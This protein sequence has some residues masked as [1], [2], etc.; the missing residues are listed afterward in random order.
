MCN[1]SEW[2]ESLALH[3]AQTCHYLRK[4]ILQLAFFFFLPLKIKKTRRAF[5]HLEKVGSYLFFFFE[6]KVV[7]LSVRET[8]R[9]GQIDFLAKGPRRVGRD[10]RGKRPLRRSGC[11]PMAGGWGP[12]LFSPV[13]PRTQRRSHFSSGHLSQKCKTPHRHCGKCRAFV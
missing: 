11:L 2:A 4:W 10:V 1:Y 12:G 3:N 7:R 13:D 5:S 8:R 6:I 9:W